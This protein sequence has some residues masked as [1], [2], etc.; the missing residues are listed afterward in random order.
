MFP[1]AVMCVSTKTLPSTYNFALFPDAY[2][3]LL[4]VTS[5]SLVII[6][7]LVASVPNCIYPLEL[8]SLFHITALPLEAFPTSK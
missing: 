5:P 2:K 7:R 3:V 8:S 1:L 4:I 6:I